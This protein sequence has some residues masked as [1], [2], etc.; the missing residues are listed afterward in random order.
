MDNGHPVRFTGFYGNVDSNNRRSSLDMLKRV[1][2]T[3]KET[4]IIERDFSV[5]LNDSKKEGGPRKPRALLDEF[6][7]FVDELSLFDLKT[8][9]GW[10]TWVNNREINAM[11]KERLDRFMIS[12]TEVANF[13]FIEIKEIRP[14][15]SDH[16]A[17]CLNTIG[18]KPKEG[19]RDQRH[20]F[21]YDIC[22]SKEKD[23]NEIVKKAWN[24]NTMN[25]LDK[26]ELV[27][28]NLGP[29]QYDQFYKMKT[30]W[31]S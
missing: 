26:M 12:V 19:A 18:R 24:D 2:S 5:I 17:I 6:R 25:I 21:R 11:V 31:W 8:D 1:G 22:C 9:K 15:S 4:W 20:S 28:Y 14:S 10:H 27:G 29:W 16:D 23:A 30:K 3:V 7:D 13:P